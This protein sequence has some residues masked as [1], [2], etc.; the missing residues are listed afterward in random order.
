MEKSN[1]TY[2]FDELGK[3]IYSTSGIIPVY[4][5]MLVDDMGAVYKVTYSKLVIEGSKIIYLNVYC[6]YR[7]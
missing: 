1:K 2:F 6:K 5:G 4:E 3:E 7:G